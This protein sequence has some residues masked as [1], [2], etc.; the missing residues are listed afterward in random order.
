MTSNNDHHTECACQLS[1]FDYLSKGSKTFYLVESLYFS[2]FF[3]YQFV[4]NYCFLSPEECLIGKVE[5]LSQN[6][7]SKWPDVS[8]EVLLF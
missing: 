1:S 3:L 8:L 7:G 5:Q 4:Y 6:I 2:A